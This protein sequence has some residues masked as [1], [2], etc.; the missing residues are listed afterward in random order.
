MD[1]V[2]NDA[3]DRAIELDDKILLLY[4]EREVE[5][6]QQRIYGGK[7]GG[8]P[9]KT[10]GFQKKRTK[11]KLYNNIY[12]LSSNTTT[13][14]IIHKLNAEYA[15]IMPNWFDS[16]NSGIFVHKTELAELLAKCIP[17]AQVNGDMFNKCLIKWDY[18]ARAQNKRA[19]LQQIFKEKQ[20]E[21][22]RN[23]RIPGGAVV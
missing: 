9:K 15:D 7:K 22:T 6:N 11:R 20:Y 14:K 10:Y 4:F 12:S 19:Y 17:L 13:K 8:R 18:I 3:L 2:F 1:T 16:T 5:R 23:K 21:K